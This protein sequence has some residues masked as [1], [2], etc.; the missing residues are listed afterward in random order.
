MQEGAN[1][2][3]FPGTGRGAF[4]YLLAT[5]DPGEGYGF[6]QQTMGFSPL[7]QA[8]LAVHNHTLARVGCHVGSHQC[9]ADQQQHCQDN[10]A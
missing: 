1:R 9:V 7:T 3:A 2:D 8:N 10:T 5:D 6:R 4:A